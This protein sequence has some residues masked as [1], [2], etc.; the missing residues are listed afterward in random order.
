MSV[1]KSVSTLRKYYSLVKPGVLWGNVITTVAGFLMASGYFQHWSTANFIAVTAGMTLVIASACAINNYLDR[2]IDARMERTKTRAVPAGLI[3]GQ[4]A[5]AL[6][7]ILLLAGLIIL[8]VWVNQL[9]VA[10]AVAGW[11]IYVWLYGALGKRRSKHGT[12]VGSISGAMPILAG[13]CAVSGRI[14]S[15]AVL[16]F[17]AI[18]FWQFPEFYSIA[19]YRRKEYKA[20][21][22][23]VMSL[24]VGLK[25]TKIQI[26]IYT[27]AFIISTLLLTILGYTGW[28]YFAVMALLGIYWL[29]LAVK[30]LRAGNSDAWARKMFH[31]SLIILLAFSA[32]LAL[33]PILP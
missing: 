14:D 28:I 21:G 6:S 4:N 29:N 22:I 20:A 32:I 5:V 2:D 23:P 13:Y 9:V 15:A 10:I 26:L 16:V 27:V 8:A 18:F 3:P 19:I 1:D 30:G 31:F 33:G 7:I 11:V 25:N 17:L 24:A 12:L